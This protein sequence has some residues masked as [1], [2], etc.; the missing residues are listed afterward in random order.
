MS[1]PGASVNIMVEACFK[2]AVFPRLDA[3]PTI[4]LIDKLIKAIAQVATSLNT[5]MWG[6]LHGF[7]ALVIE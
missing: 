5:R 2:V 4:L 1:T 3:M 6:G 7:L